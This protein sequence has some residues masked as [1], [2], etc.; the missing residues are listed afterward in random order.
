MECGVWTPNL[1]S[2]RPKQALGHASVALKGIE[3]HSSSASLHSDPADFLHS[4]KPK[5]ATLWIRFELNH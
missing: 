3:C 4:P 1:V 2:H 5:K